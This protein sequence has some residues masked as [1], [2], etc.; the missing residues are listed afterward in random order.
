MT[1]YAEFVGYRDW[2]LLNGLSLI[3]AIDQLYDK[4]VDQFTERRARR[5]PG[6]GSARDRQ[7]FK[8]QFAT[9][10]WA[11]CG[12]AAGPFPPKRPEIPNLPSGPH[13][14]PYWAERYLTL[15]HVLQL[16]LSELQAAKLLVEADGDHTSNYRQIRVPPGFWRA[17]NWALKRPLPYDRV[18]PQLIAFDSTGKILAPIYYNPRLVFVHPASPEQPPT[19]T[20]SVATIPESKPADPRNRRGEMLRGLELALEHR[21]IQSGMTQ[22]EFYVAMLDALN[23]PRDPVAR[24]FGYD[25][26]RKHCR[27]WLTERGLLFDTKDDPTTP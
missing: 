11:A 22:K 16:L 2:S 25:A 3:D 18:S 6:W 7:N 27:G 15:A 8:R 13:H 21:T 17:A 24:G 1:S 10:W 23:I 5:V 12:P 26:F 9:K 20:S 19:K 4:E 14:I